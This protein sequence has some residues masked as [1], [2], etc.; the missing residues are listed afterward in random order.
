MVTNR[1]DGIGQQV[2]LG[3]P[4]LLASVA[5]FTLALFQEGRS[6]T[7]AT[8]RHAIVKGPLKRERPKHGVGETVVSHGGLVA[9]RRRVSSGLD[10][11]QR[12]TL[13]TEI[14]AGRVTVLASRNRVCMDGHTETIVRKLGGTTLRKK[15]VPYE[16][17]K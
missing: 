12:R 1:A 3:G 10:L 16:N 5:V 2:P 4:G 17:S 7:E 6:Q 8:G 13:T 11:E 14:T 15:R 9:C